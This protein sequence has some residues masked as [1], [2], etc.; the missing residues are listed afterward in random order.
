MEKEGMVGEG[1]GGVRVG[2]LWEGSGTCDGVEHCKRWR[3]GNVRRV[4]ILND[5]IMILGI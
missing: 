5:D 4:W 3:L 2:R 1:L